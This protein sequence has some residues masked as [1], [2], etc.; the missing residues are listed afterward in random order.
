MLLKDPPDRTPLRRLV[1]QA[2]TAK[3]V[4]RLRATDRRDRRRPARRGKGTGR[5]RRDGRSRV[6][7]PHYVIAEMLGIP[8]EDRH[9]FHAWTQ[10]VNLIFEAVLTGEQTARCHDAARA[11]GDY[12]RALA[13]ERRRAPRNDVMTALIAARDEDGRLSEEELIGNA[14]MLLAAGFETTM[15]SSATA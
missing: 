10:A 15:G 4:E 6:P 2:F 13:T 14:S 12:L 5:D 9:R 8:G 3:A 1:S 7:A 11:L